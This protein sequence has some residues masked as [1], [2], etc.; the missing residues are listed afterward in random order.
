[1]TFLI[2]SATTLITSIG[3]FITRLS[4]FFSDNNCVFDLSQLLNDPAT[5]T[6]VLDP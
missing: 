5:T 3:I 1:M 6:H 4:F 2:T